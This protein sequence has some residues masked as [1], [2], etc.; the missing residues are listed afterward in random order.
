MDGWPTGARSRHNL[1]MADKLERYRAKRNATTTP[2]PPGKASTGGEPARDTARFVIQEHHAS[3]LHWDLRLEH[4]GVLASWALPKG[5][6]A[7]PHENRLAVRTE[8]HPLEYLEFHG[9]IPKGSYG[10][11]TMYIW[12]RGTYESEKFRDFEVIV[13]L[14]GERVSGKY[15]LFQTKGKNWMIHRMDPPAEEGIEP[16]PHEI[17]PMFA[18]LGELPPEREDALWGYEVKWDGVRAV[19]HVDAGHL[20]LTGRNGTD[21][22][23]RYPELRAMGNALASKR[24]IL[25]GEIV[26]FGPDGRPSFE[27]LQS[28]MHLASDSAV[29][30]RMKDIPATYVA[31]DLLWADGRPLGELP[32]AERRRLLGELDLDGASWRT[33]AHR[34]G[35]GAALLA[36]SAQQ[37]LEG[38]VAKR[39]DSSYEPGRRSGAWI[40][41]KNHGSQDVVIGGYTRGEGGRSTS[42]G[43]LC[44]GVY[45]AEGKLSYAG[46]VGTG[47]TE[48]TLGLVMSELSG[49][50]T[51]ASPFQ[52]RQPPKG[53]QFVEPQLVARVEF[54]EWTRTGTLRAPAFKGLR[55]DVDAGSVVRER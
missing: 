36:A 38:I 29:R 12:D 49:L 5:I 17:A 50:H 52:G 42:L 37:E 13:V 54:R 34:E 41:V 11:G 28:R 21:F 2:E 4:E 31:F 40:K 19:A 6:P 20:T 24:V 8:D 27:R 47:F 35:D 23:P 43:A 53:T 1:P 25:D 46:K 51:G 32:Y 7:H 9:E 3:H 45:D 16:M 39:L 15:V 33:P 22:T 18:R 14:S 30:R 26:A 55:N 48:A 10:G 44:V